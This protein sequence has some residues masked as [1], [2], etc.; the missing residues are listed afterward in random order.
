M[1]TL[2]ITL[3]LN[4]E[5]IL[6]NEKEKTFEKIPFGLKRNSENLKPLNLSE[7]FASIWN[8]LE[9]NYSFNQIVFLVGKRASF[10]DTRVIWIWLKTSQLFN[11]LDIYTCKF[12]QIDIDY[13]TANTILINEMTF[14]K[15]LQISELNSENLVYGQPVKIT[16]PLKT[17]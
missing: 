5:L 6:N 4:L 10:T 3:D 17:K 8:I 12:D 7:Y 1:N 11:N 2:I 14:E 9:T 15:I 16:K 13:K